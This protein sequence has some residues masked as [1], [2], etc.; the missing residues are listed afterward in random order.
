MVEHFLE[1]GDYT[2][3]VARIQCTNP[4][5]KEE[6][7]RPFSCKTFY[8]CPS[9]SQ[10]RTLLFSEY[11]NEQLLLRLPHRQFVWTFPKLLRPFFRHDGGAQ[12]ADSLANSRR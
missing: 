8:F 1:C 2:K 5:C 9:C 10:K 7:F 6:Y 3:G 12:P 4:A 11:M